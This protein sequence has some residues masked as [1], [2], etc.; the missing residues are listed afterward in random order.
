MKKGPLV[1][2]SVGAVV[3]LGIA[4]LLVANKDKKNTHTAAGATT[5]AAIDACERYTLEEAKDV[6][7]DATTKGDQTTPTSSEDMNVSTCSYT[8]NAPEAKDLRVST[9][10]IRSPLTEIGVST[11]GEAFASEKPEGTEDV[12]GYG[13]K[14]Y[15][16]PATGQMSVLQQD[17]WFII[18]TGA[19]A[20]A[21]RTLDE[22][23]AVADKVFN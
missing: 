11:N 13:E 4:L 15:W 8:S 9:V 7:G 23:K 2:V 19:A 3:V 16:D 20:P 14:A 18:N 6:L 5:F 12:S 1:W 17:R 10:L 22:A 21:Q